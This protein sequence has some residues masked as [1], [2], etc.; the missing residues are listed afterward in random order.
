MTVERRKHQHCQ[1]RTFAKIEVCERK[2]RRRTSHSRTPKKKPKRDKVLKHFW[3]T[4]VE[5]VCQIVN[6]P[7]PPDKED[8]AEVVP[9]TPHE[10]D[11]HFFVEQS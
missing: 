4:L 11:Q 2:G 5:D 1:R 9:I 10:R 8:I 3:T 6:A 7:V